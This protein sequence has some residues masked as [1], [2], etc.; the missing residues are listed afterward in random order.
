M[1]PLSQ[2]IATIREVPLLELV[3]QRIAL[4]RIHDGGVVRLGW[5]YLDQGFPVPVYLPSVLDCFV[6]QGIAAL[7]EPEPMMAHARRLHLTLD[8]LA[9]H[10]VVCGQPTSPPRPH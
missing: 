9:L 4:R 10:A 8:G 1:L 5:R 7:G 2:L 6:Q 3:H